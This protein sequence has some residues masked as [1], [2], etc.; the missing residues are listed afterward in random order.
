MNLGA[1]LTIVQQKT[2]LTTGQNNIFDFFINRD[3]RVF[4]LE[5]LVYLERAK[6]AI[7]KLYRKTYK[8]LRNAVKSYVI[9]TKDLVKFML[10]MLPAI[11]KVLITVAP[12]FLQQ[13][14]KASK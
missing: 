14:Y 12:L 4:T 10:E 2:Q 5:F 11:I 13:Q 9:P 6:A 8:G 7:R 3:I 1:A